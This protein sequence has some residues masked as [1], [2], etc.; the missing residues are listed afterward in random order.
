M[1]E[2]APPPPQSQEELA[3]RLE[4]RIGNRPNIIVSFETYFKNVF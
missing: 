4:I 2:K 1:E 3:N